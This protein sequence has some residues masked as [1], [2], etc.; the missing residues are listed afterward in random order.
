M[1]KKGRSGKDTGNGRWENTV[2]DGE[3]RKGKGE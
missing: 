2:T 1:I 3:R